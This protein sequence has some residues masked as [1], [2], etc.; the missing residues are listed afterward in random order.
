MNLP[1]APLTYTDNVARTSAVERIVAR[2]AALPGVRSAAMTTMV[3][4]AGAGT[5]IHFNRAARPPKGPEDYVMAGFRAVTPEYLSVLRVPLERGRML[6]ATDNDR[7]P[8][9]VVVNES[10]ARQFFPGINPIGQRHPARYR[11]VG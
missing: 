5:T 10:M 9:V 4:M 3:P 8:R 2:V 11:A 6:A 7:A 1:L